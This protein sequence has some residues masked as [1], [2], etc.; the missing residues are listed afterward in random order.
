[1]D[2]MGG[3]DSTDN[4]PSIIIGTVKFAA[5]NMR[6]NDSTLEETLGVSEYGKNDIHVFC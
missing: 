6:Q 5:S 4:A 2:V 3:V 1:M